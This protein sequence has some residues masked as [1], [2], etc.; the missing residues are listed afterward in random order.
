LPRLPL[1]GAVLNLNIAENDL[2]NGLDARARKNSR[3][4]LLSDCLRAK[5][6]EHPL[7]LMLEDVHWI[8][9]LSRDLLELI[10]RVIK[11]LPVL[12]LLAYRPEAK[13]LLPHLGTLEYASEVRL[14][15]L[16]RDE[17]EEMIAARLGYFKLDGVVTRL[18][19]RAQGN[20]FYIE[21][22]LNYM[23]DR[24]LDPRE[25]SAWEPGA[26]PDSLQSLILS[27]IDQ[28][29]EQQQIT[30]K[31]ASI[32]GRLFRVIWLSEYYPPLGGSQ[33]VSA[34][35]EVLSRLELIA[36]ETPAPQL[37][38]LFKHVITQEVAYESLAYATRAGLHEQ[39][40]RY[41]ELLAGPDV[42]PYLDLLAYHYER[43]D[44]LAKKREYL[45]RAGE[46][47]QAAYA[48]EAA[49]SY[50]GRALALAPEADYAGRFAILAVREQ[51]LN[52]L[53]KREAQSQDLTA[54]TALAEAL[55]DNERRAQA[56]VNRAKYARAI[57]DYPAAIAAA[58]L[59]VE[60]G[61]LAGANEHE[62]R[63]YW[64][65]GEAL[66]F[67][68]FY[69]EA[70]TRYE[71]ALALAQTAGLTNLTANILM[72]FGILDT[73]TSEYD[74][75]QK[76]L[77]QALQ[78]Q[79]QGG[80]R[81]GENLVLSSLGDSAFLRGDFVN[82][83]AY[84]EQTL[85][86]WRSI[87]YKQSEGRT[88]SRL[89]SLI[90]QQASDFDKAKLYSEQALPLS[91]EAG[92]RTGEMVAFYN[93]SDIDLTRNNY[94]LARTQAEKALGICREIS[95]RYY[96][97]GCLTQLGTIADELGEYARA[98][99]DHNQGVAVLREIGERDL[100]C[101]I[102][103][104]S[105]IVYYHLGRLDQAVE[106]NRQALAIVGETK[107]DLVQTRVSTLQ[108]HVLRN[109]GDLEQAA[110]AYHQA[111]ELSLKLGMPQYANQ[112]QTGLACLALAKGKPAA[113]QVYMDG[114]LSYLATDTSG[115]RD[116]IIWI[117]LSCYRI[118][119]ANADPRARATLQAGYSL[120]QQI[121]ARIDNDDLK[122]SFLQNVRFNRELAQTWGRQAPA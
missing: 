43:S 110:A 39:F 63:G 66:F 95:Y 72:G 46:A 50:L 37:A 36:E 61:R 47:A 58:Q 121:A 99:E 103:T 102:L 70:R 79:R 104:A 114:I 71:Q 120:L 60:L 40:A 57:N 27:R 8:D 91:Q 93:L 16:T 25:E 88:L 69:A 80:D 98:L 76:Y 31:A 64:L 89:A 49:L 73:T 83:Q 106:A 7:V 35:L 28:L 41:L 52:I 38:Y 65:W 1:L 44:N 111:L 9:P 42:R 116:E 2:T 20:P 4:A 26:L 59:A 105:A 45:R 55:D 6:A 86:S 92:D 85:Q 30:L 101:Q 77:E 3:E 115:T 14:V 112:A 78:L 53:G 119:D 10:G 122:A 19:A 90:I 56:A 54:L 81:I 100:M 107:N 108:G 117:Y 5:A 84:Y 118:L 67:Q 87:G 18:Q 13:T 51:V 75:A 82:A 62:A 23:R 11:E 74:S 48:N 24:G 29:S 17:T 94:Q 68:G 97:G 21:E 22:L 32:I 109:L 96:E 12:V 113:A 33:R 15:E 34:E